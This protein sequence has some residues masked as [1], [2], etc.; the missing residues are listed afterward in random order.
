MIA[1]ELQRD[2][3]AELEI[4]LKDIRTK[5]ISGELKDGVSAYEQQLPEI[6]ADDEDPA[7]F[8]PYAIVKLDQGNTEDDDDWWHVRASILFGVYDDDRKTNGHRH[9][10]EMINRTD[11]RFDEEPLL[12]KRFRAEPRRQ[13]ALQD[14]DTF[15]FYFGGI[16]IIFAVPKVGRKDKS[17][18]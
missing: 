13:W 4:I 6:T 16:E 11:M 14:E 9:I 10:L 15:P 17:Y 8:F 18:E 12:S 5:T 7:M 1:S 3:V 2:L